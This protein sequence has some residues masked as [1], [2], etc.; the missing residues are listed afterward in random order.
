MKSII[1]SAPNKVTLCEIPEPLVGKDEVLIRVKV[2]GICHTDYEILKGNYG[3]NA[4]PLIPGHEFSGVIV[5]VGENV[6]QFKDGDRVVV[7]PNIG[8]KNCKA[9]ARGWIN[10]CE[11]LGAY[12]VTTNGGF[13]EFCAV[14]SKRVHTIGN[15]SFKRAALAEPMGCIL[16]ALDTVHADWIKNVLIFG[17]GPMGILMG[18]ALKQLGITEVTY[19]DIAQDRLALA[20]SFG[21]SSVL[22]GTKDLFNWRKEADLAVEATGA[23]TVAAELTNYIANGGKGLFFGV[24]QSEL[25]INVSPF[26]IMCRQLMLSGSHSLNRNIPRSLEVISA[27]GVELDSIISHEVDLSEICEF[28]GGQ[29]PRKSL[30]VQWSN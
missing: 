11:N 9:C 10:L 26:D 5:K 16:N 27:L 2:S 4:F 17:A 6:T 30:K 23:S 25:K 14:A 3:K 12:G 29:M 24:C 28:L 13:S 8:C 21:F 18:L 15:I 19:C 22:S 20:E 7:D 1:F